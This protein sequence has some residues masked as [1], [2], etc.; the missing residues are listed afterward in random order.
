MSF[1]LKKKIK[2]KHAKDGFI[3]K[4]LIIILYPL[5]IFIFYFLFQFI[6]RLI[7]KY[8]HKIKFN[9]NGKKLPSKP[10]LVLGNH[11]TDWDGLYLNT[12]INRFIYFLVHDEVF[13]YKYRKI[14]AYNL[15]GQIKRGKTKSDIGPL[16]KLVDLKNSGKCIGIFP[17]GDISY[18]GK[19][20][21]I[22]K[23]IAKL[24]KILNM[25][26]VLTRIDG[27]TYQRPRWGYTVRKYPSEITLTDVICVEDVHNLT[28][29]ELFNR[30]KNGIYYNDN[31][32]QNI[33]N[34][35]MRAKK[36]AE[37]LEN[38]LFVCPDCKNMNCL[39]SKNDIIKCN[40]C[41]Y[42]AKYN[43]Y[44]RF[45]LIKGNTNLKNI[46]QWDEFQKSV[47]PQSVQK[48]LKK[49]EELI[50]MPNF[51]YDKVKRG[52]FFYNYQDKG[53]LSINDKRLK[54]VSHLREFEQTFDIKDIK[55]LYIQFKGAVEFTF[56]D[57]RYRFISSEGKH[58]GYRYE[59]IIN[60]FKNSQEN[61][62]GK[63]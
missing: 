10:F 51:T 2:I 19:S 7:F 34:K 29:E 57:Y 40:I 47:L 59:C 32:Y 15:L 60:M 5:R 23:S 24:S 63:N 38:V 9:K 42:T 1:S 4:L 55:D 13:K 35:K 20:L 16:R 43:L 50:S 30:I 28:E 3:D 53:V 31:E 14:I 18:T 46:D 61:D 22:N 44:N 41:N 49:G 37:K 36:A 45:E 33:H 12:Y 48:A 39:T 21:S 26:I 58:Y 25:P 54:F 17:E 6:F 62:V 8:V 27:A 56:G 52:E 11:V